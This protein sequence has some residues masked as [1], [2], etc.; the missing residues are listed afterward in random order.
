MLYIFLV[1]TVG[2][3]TFHKGH[4]VLGVLGIVLPFL[5]L[6]GALLPD[7]NEGMTTGSGGMRPST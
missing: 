2:Y 5:W 6:I 1:F 3:I 7:R 4:F